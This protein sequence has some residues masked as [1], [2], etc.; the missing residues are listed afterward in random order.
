MYVADADVNTELDRLRREC[1]E[2]RSQLALVQSP[3]EIV[4]IQPTIIGMLYLIVHAC[5][6]QYH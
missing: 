5:V 4:D 2:L 6:Y 3:E 1:Q